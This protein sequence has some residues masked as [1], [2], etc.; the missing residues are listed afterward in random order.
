MSVHDVS[1]PLAAPV[2]PGNRALGLVRFVLP[3]VVLVAG[4]GLWELVVRL[5]D[6]KPYVLPAPSVDRKSVV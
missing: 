6:I 1:P 2:R 3:V 4:V 5:N